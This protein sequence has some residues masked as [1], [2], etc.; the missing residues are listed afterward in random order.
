MVF[1]LHHTPYEDFITHVSGCDESSCNLNSPVIMG[2][3]TACTNFSQQAGHYFKQQPH[4]GDS[5][6]IHPTMMIDPL[7]VSY[8]N[9]Y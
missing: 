3:S 4:V 9:A 6:V 5:Q 8:V 2:T 1:Y 7:M